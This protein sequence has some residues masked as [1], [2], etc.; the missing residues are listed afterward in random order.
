MGTAQA[1]A[2]LIV[3]VQR[4]RAGENPGRESVA[5]KAVMHV[6]S[7]LPQLAPRASTTPHALALAAHCRLLSTSTCTSRSTG[8]AVQRSWTASQ[9][10]RLAHLLR[11][12]KLAQTTTAGRRP[13]GVVHGEAREPAPRRAR[14]APRHVAAQES[15][16]IASRESPMPRSDG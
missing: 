4:E 2:L 1:E 12:G 3:A 16:T 11:A 6:Q 10:C 15:E 14:A 9:P 8:G 5:V 13:A 7:R